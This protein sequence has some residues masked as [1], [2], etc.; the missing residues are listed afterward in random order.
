MFN[1]RRYF[2]VASLTAFA[3]A[4]PA[5]GLF[6][7]QR[8]MESLIDVVKQRNELLT[9]TV[10]NS[11]WLEHGDFLSSADL[12]SDENLRFSPGMF[13]L[14]ETIFDATQGLPVIKIR[15]LSLDGR[16]LYSTVPAQIGSDGS[17]SEGFQAARKGQPLS[18]FKDAKTLY[19][20]VPLLRHHRLVSS[21]VPLQVGGA[22][23]KTSG[24]IELYTDVTPSVR[25]VKQTQLTLV[26][27]LVAIC[28]LLYGTLFIIIARADRI[29]KSQNHELEAT[30]ESLAQANR[31]LESQVSER[32]AALQTTNKQLQQTLDEL[33]Q[34]QEQLI[35]NEKMSSLGQLIAGIAHEVNTPLG[36]IASSA[37]SVSKFL[38]QMVDQV[39]DVIQQL[40]A[41]DGVYFLA[42]L[43]L[44]LK[45][46]PLRSTKEERKLRRSLMRILD[47][48]SIADATTIADTLVDIGL[49]TDNVETV[50]PLLKVSDSQRLLETIYKLSS[51]KRGVTTIEVASERASKVMFALKN[52]SRYDHTNEPVTVNVLDGIETTLT[53]YHH[54]IKRGVEVKRHYESLPLVQCYADELAQVWTNL[55]HNALQ[56]MSHTGILTIAA[57]SMAWE[58]KSCRVG[59]SKP[60]LCEAIQ[61]SITDTG[62]GI[63]EDIQRRIFEPFFTTKAAGEGS[64][65]GL[66]IVKKIIEKHRGCITVA[67]EP[68]QT[69]FTV[70]LPLLQGSDEETM[71]CSIPSLL[72]T[73]TVTPAMATV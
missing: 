22:E 5:M 32:T 18:L 37:G 12:L 44:S 21:S 11:L 6:S 27:G 63:P 4:I 1:L 67:S 71:R 58:S 9:E 50:L 66:D 51:I 36:A 60:T 70:T 3:I 14:R 29:L 8:A 31:D 49:D 15:I 53:L 20:G 65:L 41:E 2:S 43:Q 54:Q 19:K 16:V 13:D 25:K 64:G 30:K 68:G 38:A 57:R 40:S 7:Y 59:V 28:S 73:K 55:I 46:S 62:T 61:I 26:A 35:H 45:E 39:P 42:V 17:Q 48:E 10:G 33:T 72:A 69:T 52:Y 23:E 34:T 24:I 47:Q 56:A